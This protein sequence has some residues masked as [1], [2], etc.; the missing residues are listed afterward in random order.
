MRARSVFR[1]L[2]AI[3]ALLYAISQPPKCERTESKA[4]EP[5]KYRP[6]RPEQGACPKAVRDRT[7]SIAPQMLLAVENDYITRVNP[8]RQRT[9]KRDHRPIGALR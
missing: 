2:E 4:V 7:W 5:P 3:F 1:S 8:H 9:L 6:Q